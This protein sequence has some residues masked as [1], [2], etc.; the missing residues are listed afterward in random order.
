MILWRYWVC[1]FKEDGDWFSE[2]KIEDDNGE[3]INDEFV[4][5]GV[6]VVVAVEGVFEEVEA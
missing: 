6:V 5:F 1:W 4:L 2:F 3:R